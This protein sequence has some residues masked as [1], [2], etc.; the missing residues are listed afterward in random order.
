MKE[1]KENNKFEIKKEYVSFSFSSLCENKKYN[2]DYLD[3]SKDVRKG[4]E[5]YKNLMNRI[6]EIEN[7]AW[8]EFIQKHKDVG[9]ETLKKKNLKID[10]D[11]KD[12]KVIV[13]RFNDKKCRIVGVKE[14]KVFKI[15]A[16][17]FDFTLYKH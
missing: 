3:K 12:E 14:E 17:D 10:L 2:F 13:I 7:T 8:V 1:I 6:I 16:F 11:I 15:L 9:I 4:F 5:I